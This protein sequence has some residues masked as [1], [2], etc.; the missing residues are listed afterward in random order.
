M[1]A[2]M[3]QKPT[4]PSWRPGENTACRRA[5]ARAQNNF[6]S[7]VQKERAKERAKAKARQRTSRRVLGMVEKTQRALMD[8]FFVALFAAPHNIFVF[9]AHKKEK[10]KD[11]DKDKDNIKIRLRPPLLRR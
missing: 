2:Q 3:K 9:V 11:K 10:E 8:K 1:L 7:I 5:R 4:L 6:L